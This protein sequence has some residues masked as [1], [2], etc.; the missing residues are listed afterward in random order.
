MKNWVKAALAFLGFLDFFAFCVILMNFRQSLPGSAVQGLSMLAVFALPHLMLWQRLKHNTPALNSW[1]LGFFYSFT[2]M[3]AAF[4]VL[5]L[6]D[7][8]PSFWARLAAS[9]L[10]PLALFALFFFAR[11]HRGKQ[12]LKRKR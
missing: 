4:A 3:F 12:L 11:S 9:L 5:P 8:I 10:L 6:E 1:S 7:V 2:V